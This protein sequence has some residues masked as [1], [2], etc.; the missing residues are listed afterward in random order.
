MHSALSRRTFAAIAVTT[1][2]SLGYGV[3]PSAYAAGTSTISGSVWNDANR[4][5][6]L[7]GGES[8]FA[9]TSLYVYDSNGYYL[10]TSTT[11]ASGH[12]QLSGLA[13]GSY[14]VAFPNPTWMSMRDTWV[15]TTTG[16][17]YFKRAVSLSG[18]AVADFGLRQIVRSTDMNTPMSQVT[19]A[20]GTVVQSFD[21]AVPARDIAAALT[22]GQLFG[23]EAAA[24]AVHFDIGSQT[25]A[26]TSWAT[27]ASGKYC[28][29]R[30]DLW[31]AYDSWLDNQDMVLFHEYGHAWG[32]YNGVVVQQDPSLTAYLQARGVYGNSLL[33]SSKAWTPTEMLAEDY[34][35]LFASPSA[36]AYP[37]ANTD[38]PPAASVPGLKSWLSTTFTQPPS[39]T[40]S[41]D[42]TTSGSTA[43][44]AVTV[45]GLAV[46]PQPVVKSGTVS[47]SL[48]AA[49]TT[50]VTV[51]TSSGALVK[52][53]LSSAT[54]PSGQVSVTWNRTNNKGKRV[55]SGT[56][57]VT[58]HAVD[59]SGQTADSSLAFPVS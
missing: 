35:Q 10:A 44:A 13:D 41:T 51:V 14:T 47:F 15:P 20:D 53:L 3:A 56:Y 39:S 57:T 46:S 36:A 59:A 42:T 4:N 48:S 7:D 22:Q 8:P 45:S 55:S 19:M 16:S 1:L 9:N 32:W 52:N 38:I 49:A 29:F 6:V 33:N 43:P 27:D 18:S 28:C 24:I 34:R 17:V 31:I 25:D 23:P 2:V 21:D 11:D 50:T 26:T 58:V 5:G 37:Q 40:G 12:Y 30:S 54:E